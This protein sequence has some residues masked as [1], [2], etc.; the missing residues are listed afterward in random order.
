MI[1]GGLEIEASGRNDI[2]LPLHGVKRAEPKLVQQMTHSLASDQGKVTVTRERDGRAKLS[3]EC[4]SMALLPR[5]PRAFA[6][7]SRQ[8]AWPVGRHVPVVAL[9]SAALSLMPEQPRPGCRLAFLM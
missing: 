3:L 2:L 5:L 1:K 4:I 6:W 7:S 8:A 9:P